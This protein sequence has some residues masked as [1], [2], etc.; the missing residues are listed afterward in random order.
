MLRNRKAQAILELAVLGSLIIMA[1]S[2]A[3]QHSE[4]SNREQS[5]MQQTFRAALKA[6]KTANSSAQWETIDFRRMSNVTN[7]ME[8][9]E[10]QQFSSSNNV[11]WSDG[12]KDA[13]TGEPINK[14]K[15]WFQ[16]NRGSPVEIPPRAQLPFNV[17]ETSHTSYTSNANVTTTFQK[18]EYTDGQ[19]ITHKSLVATDSISGSAD[20]SGTTVDLGSSL[21][22]G[23][24]YT[25]GGINR[26]ESMQ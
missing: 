12:K 3:I 8:L 6:A 4:Q 2:I 10:L 7:P 22:E 24:K 18:N 21:G 11:L 15:S 26:S 19:I 25:G 5:Y 20:I 16:L 13:D 14:P 17:S 9:G 23:G 1:F